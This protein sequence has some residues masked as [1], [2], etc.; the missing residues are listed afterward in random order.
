[1]DRSEF[2]PERDLQKGPYPHRGFNDEL[3][4][5]IEESIERKSRWKRLR[6]SAA[7]TTFAAV[8]AFLL[9]MD[10]NG[11]PQPQAQT[12]LS[13]T[14]AAASPAADPAPA[15]AGNSVSDTQMQYQSGLLIGL[16]ADFKRK[17]AKLNSDQLPDSSYRT[18]FIAPVNGN[19]EV[20][21]EGKGILLPYGQMF[22]KIDAVSSSSG[23]N[24]YNTVIAHPA[25]KPVLVPEL[26]PSDGQR[27]QHTEKLLFVGNKYVS[28]EQTETAKSGNKKLQTSRIWVKELQ[29]VNGQ[30]TAAT[31]DPSKRNYVPFADLFGGSSTDSSQW[32]ILRRPGSW[33][34]NIADSVFNGDN[35]S[36][37]LRPVSMPLPDAVVSHDQL[38]CAWADIVRVQPSAVDALSSPKKDFLAVVT[39][40]NLFFYE[41]RGGKLGTTPKATVN[42]I[43]NE[44][45]IMAQWSTGNYVEEWIKA[46]RTY[47][48]KSS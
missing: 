25:N 36:Y 44:T 18:L 24:I 33:V 37:M 29:Q 19:L 5:R 30:L 6:L 46:S 13:V 39:P 16:R 9:I 7:F 31:A 41:T 23:G 21:A 34:P 8:G 42:L 3:Q 2:D 43:E 38:C 35:E 26:Q 27:V 28:L 17:S 14:T 4:K 12:E 48:K 20:A 10:W 47:L 45:V 22:W 11:W 15:E 40:T 32:A 1:M